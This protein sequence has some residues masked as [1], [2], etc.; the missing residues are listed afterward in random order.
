M[1]NIA[2]QPKIPAIEMLR[3]LAALVVA[4][5]HFT[6]GFARH[7]DDRLGVHEQ[8]GDLAQVAVA[9][10]FVISG[11][12]MVL[13]ARGLYGQI[14]GAVTFWRRRVVRVLPS[15]WIATLLLALVLLALGQN[16]KPGELWRSL[17]FVPYRHEP[18]AAVFLPFLWPG[19]TLFYE[20]VFYALFGAFVFAGK[21][22]TILLTAFAPTGLVVAGLLLEPRSIA[23]IAITRPVLLLFIA[24]MA[25]LSLI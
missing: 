4:M 15:Y 2:S 14:S 11:C 20:L 17:I 13:S 23:A 3:A 7:I 16:V 18:G 22:W 8:S 19:W 25:M 1:P 9:L 12:V 24:G 6:N 5:V 21:R 10:F